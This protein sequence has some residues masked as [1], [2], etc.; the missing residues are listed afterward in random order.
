[1][2][3]DPE[4][5]YKLRLLASFREAQSL[6]PTRECGTSLGVDSSPRYGTLIVFLRARS[7]PCYA[8]SRPQQS[9]AHKVNMACRGHS[10]LS[11]LLTRY[12]AKLKLQIC[13][14]RRLNS[15][16]IFAGCIRTWP[17]LQPPRSCNATYTQQMRWKRKDTAEAP[18]S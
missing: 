4:S 13:N 10:P 15:S 1:M 16:I 7:H 9:L 8:T 3:L 14:L 2:I 17:Q 18:T 5:P 6:E 12:P 11:P